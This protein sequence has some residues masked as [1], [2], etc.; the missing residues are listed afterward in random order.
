MRSDRGEIVL[1]TG[2]ET[3]ATARITRQLA[4]AEGSVLARPAS[5][6]A[7]DDALRTETQRA[8]ELAV[9]RAMSG[10]SEHDGFERVI[11][12]AGWRADPLECASA[13][14]YAVCDAR[15][16]QLWRAEVPFRLQFSHV[17]A[18]VTA[19]SLLADLACTTDVVA[20]GGGHLRTIGELL[21]CQMEHASVIVLT[22]I[23]RVATPKLA[24]V[25]DVV[26]TL[27]PAAT[28]ISQPSDVAPVLPA[29]AKDVCAL[30]GTSPGWL[31]ALSS[32][33]PP[34]SGGI[35]RSVFSSGLPFHSQRLSEFLAS[36]EIERA[37][38]VIRS[39]GLV[40]L[41]TRPGMLG[42]WASAGAALHLDPISTASR[43]ADLMV[44]SEIAFF[45]READARRILSGL[46]ECVLTAEEFAA[47]PAAWRLVPDDFPSWQA[48]EA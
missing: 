4:A 19:P 46:G 36:G 8:L 42:I 21:A 6:P 40:T 9:E 34:V 1:V 41:C 7:G 10:A 12:R 31:R 33:A 29:A 26:R 22:D 30:V 32:D 15:E 23:E 44:G 20:E 11:V 27:N 24:H 3:G 16:E 28:I 39:K 37:G 2:L 14:H 25:V 18:V 43:E 13:L 45:T 35:E 47:G 48:E 38:G 5:F 17:V